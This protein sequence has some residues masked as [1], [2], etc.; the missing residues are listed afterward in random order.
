[1]QDKLDGWIREFEEFMILKNFS[2]RTI[3][4][5]DQNKALLNKLLGLQN[6][7][8]LTH[9]IFHQKCVFLSSINQSTQITNNMIFPYSNTS[10]V[11]LEILIPNN[12][13][14]FMK[15]REINISLSYAL[16]W[17]STSPFILS[18]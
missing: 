11:Q 8:A 10:L 13:C 5:Y 9:Y 18:V 14:I 2:P 12:G 6:Y 4:T 7:K 3:K 17:K 15:G 16:F 1:M